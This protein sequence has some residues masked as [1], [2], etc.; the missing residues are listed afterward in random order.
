MTKKKLEKNNQTTAAFLKLISFFCLFRNSK[1]LNFQ[2][3]IFIGQ[4]LTDQKSENSEF[5]IQKNECIIYGS[6]FIP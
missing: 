5:Y 4:K 3:Q 6:F 1:Q 2:F